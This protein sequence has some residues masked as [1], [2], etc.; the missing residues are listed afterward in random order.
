MRVVITVRTL[1]GGLTWGI[2]LLSSLSGVS[3]EAI[4]N[5]K[6]TRDQPVPRYLDTCTGQEDVFAA[7]QRADNSA[8][9]FSR[10]S[11][12]SPPFRH[13]LGLSRIGRDRS[14]HQPWRAPPLHLPVGHP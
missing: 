9:F 2:K 3:F 5:E 8:S 4:V 13:V 1:D 14:T 7:I 12:M 6:A 11:A 10:S